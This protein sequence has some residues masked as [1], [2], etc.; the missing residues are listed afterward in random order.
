MERG[1]KVGKR[2][3]RKST[4]KVFFL[5]PKSSLYITY[6][7]NKGRKGNI[8]HVSVLRWRTQKKKKKAHKSGINTWL[9]DGKDVQKELH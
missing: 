8:F 3:S 1:G 5:P 4:A 6:D 9:G 7:L 2:E